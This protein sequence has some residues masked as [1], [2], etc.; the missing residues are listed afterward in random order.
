MD[1]ECINLCEQMNR[2]PGIRT[3]ESC[4]G[5]G[6]SDYH[7]WFLVDNMMLLPRLIYWFAGCHCG[8]YGWHVEVT[9]DCG[10]SPVH[11]S[12]VGPKEYDARYKI[13]VYEEAEVI[14][15]CL[16]DYADRMDKVDWVDDEIADEEELS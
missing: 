1:K 15:E 9:T 14:A 13:G 8:I 6:N 2:Y 12:L 10:M 4:C 16:K 11:F 3:F 7:I 5:H